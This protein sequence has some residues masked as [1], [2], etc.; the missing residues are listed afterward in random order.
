MITPASVA[1]QRGKRKNYFQEFQT[2]LGRIKKVFFYNHHSTKSALNLISNH[3]RHM[4]V[5]LCI[6]LFRDQVELLLM[7]SWSIRCWPSM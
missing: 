7:D 6:S 2:F 3:R 5:S 4:V 1:R